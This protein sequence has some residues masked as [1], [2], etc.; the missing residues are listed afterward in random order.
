M[1]CKKKKWK[2]F[3]SECTAYLIGKYGPF[4]EL[5]G[6]S[7]STVSDILVNGGAVW[8]SFYI[9]IK[10]SDSQSGQFV[11][12]PDFEHKKFRYSVKN[13]TPENYYSHQ[14]MEFMNEQFEVFS[15]SGTKGNNIDISKDIMYGWILSHYKE[16]NV[17]FFITKDSNR[18]LI[19]PIQSFEKYFDVSATYRVKKSGSSHLTAAGKEDFIVA[20]DR[21]GIKYQFKG[22]DVI[23]DDDL[24]GMKVCGE[25]YNYLLKEDNLQYK[26]KRLSNTRNLNVIFSL[27]LK[28]YNEVQRHKDLREFE[29]AIGVKAS[30]Y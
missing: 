24:D 11:L 12:K 6:E 22:L 4:F 7:D 3:E 26:V 13:R 30:D 14:I 21:V 25:R 20:L 5:K 16:M 28:K 29:T 15:D 23:A 1:R 27:Y 17:R 2:E 10:M 18:F 8:E 9:E 19:F